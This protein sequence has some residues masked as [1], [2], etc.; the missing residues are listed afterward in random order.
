MK[1]KREEEEE[2]ESNLMKGKTRNSGGG[3]RLEINFPSMKKWKKW[4][5]KFFKKRILFVSMRGTKWELKG[6]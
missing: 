6:E 2:E 5:K 4:R 3:E 1:K